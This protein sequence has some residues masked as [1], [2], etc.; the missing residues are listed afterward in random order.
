MIATDVASRGLDIPDVAFVINYDLPTNIESYIH[1]IGRTGRIGKTGTAISFVTDFDEPMYNKLYNVLKDSNQEI[2]A[3]FKE[4]VGSKYQ[5]EERYAPQ[6]RT[7]GKPFHHKW[8]GGGGGGYGG[9]RGYGGGRPGGG[10]QNNNNDEDMGYDSDYSRP[11]TTGGFNKPYGG[12]GG[13]N[14]YTGNNDF[15]YE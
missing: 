4:I 11:H 7:G 5:R 9:N 12:A 15:G 3:W 13:G 1:R 10:F 8:R 14:Y 6:G 2:P